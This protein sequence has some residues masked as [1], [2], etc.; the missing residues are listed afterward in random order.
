MSSPGKR[1]NDN[2]Y[3]NNMTWLCVHINNMTWLCVRSVCTELVEKQIIF[4]TVQS[5]EMEPNAPKELKEMHRL[6]CGLIV[7]PESVAF[8]QP[9]DWKT[10]GLVDY[11]DIVKNPMDLGTI[12]ANLEASK[13]QTKEEV[14]ADIRLVWTNCMLYNS[15][16]SEV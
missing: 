12:K 5:G 13:Y 14:A 3:I 1:I 2:Q 4:V 15:D 6:V 8:R 10:L 9:V 7:R 11:M 16:G